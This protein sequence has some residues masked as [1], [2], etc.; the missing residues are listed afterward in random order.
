M[1]FSTT[2]NTFKRYAAG[3]EA[4]SNFFESYYRAIPDRAG[5]CTMM[6][7]IYFWRPLIAFL[8]MFFMAFPVALVATLGF[9]YPLRVGVGIVIVTLAIGSLVALVKIMTVGLNA[10]KN[11]ERTTR[12][13]QLGLLGTWAKAAHDKVCPLVTF[14][15]E[16]EDSNV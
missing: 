1:E 16:E 7:T 3:Y 6:R 2:S 10:I 14:T 9:V 11:R 12:N 15:H 5:F 8:R 4:Y 13:A